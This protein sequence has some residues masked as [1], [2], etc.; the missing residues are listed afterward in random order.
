MLE[1]ES[2]VTTPADPAGELSA[3]RSALRDLVALSALPSSWTERGPGAIAQD[4]IDM[5]LSLL[6]AD[7][8]IARLPPSLA[9]EGPAELTRTYRQHSPEL[10]AIA[11]AALD[12]MPSVGGPDVIELNTTRG[13]VRL[14]LARLV[15]DKEEGLLA[16]GSRRA[17]FPTPLETALL[18]IAANHVSAALRAAEL[19]Q[20]AREA[21][22]RKDSF[23]ALL[24]HELR[25]PLASIRGSIELLTRSRTVS[26]TERSA[27]EIIDRQS[28]HLARMVDDLLNLTRLNVG[29]LELRRETLDLR[30]VARDAFGSFK[31]AGRFEGYDADLRLAEEIIPVDGDRVRLEQVVA[32]LVDNALKFTPVGG[33]VTVSVGQAAG[34]GVLAVEDTGTGIAP[35]LLPRVFEAFIQDRRSGLHGLGLGLGLAVVR[36]IAKLHGGDVAVRENPSA[37]GTRIEV[38]LPL[39]KEAAPPRSEP[40][41]VG[42]DSRRILLVD[43]DPDIRSALRALLEL[44]DHLVTVAASGS[45]GLTLALADPPDIALVDIG[46][47]DMDGYEVM[48]R[49]RSDDRGKRIFAVALTGYGQA[50]DARRALAAGFDVHLTK[51]V[52]HDK[53]TA[54]LRSERRPATT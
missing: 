12:A 39:S 41:A 32:N 52:E 14:A 22:R 1:A 34:W 16:I 3:F 31:V 28:R 33:S 15:V 26:D 25:N 36:S 45:E 11:R 24:G 2:D 6:H 47:P 50:E 51:P 7:V 40:A 9:G 53:L 29:T 8:G 44:D 46:L 37:P 17:D 19:L 27:L 42:T 35:D 54:V 18:R 21:D 49:I 10:P 5:T 4:A 20:R 38:R 13:D 23:I 48:R 43:D 30:S